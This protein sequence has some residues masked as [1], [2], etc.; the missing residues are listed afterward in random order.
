MS[1]EEE[2]SPYND[3]PEESIAR[4][5]YIT[6]NVET[7]GGNFIGRDKYIDQATDEDI[8]LENLKKRP[9]IFFREKNANFHSINT[10]GGDFIAG[11]VIA[12]HLHIEKIENFESL[13]PQPCH[14]PCIPPYQGLLTFEKEDTKRFFGR[15]QLISR[16]IQK[17]HHT[18][19]LTI[20][21][22]SGS[23]KSSVVRAGVIPAV[24]REKELKRDIPY[25]GGKWQAVVLT[26]TAKPLDHLSYVLSKHVNIAKD[27]LLSQ[28]NEGDD[29]LLTIFKQHS[30]AQS[31]NQLLVVDQFEELFTLCLDEETRQIFIDNLV[32]INSH[33]VTNVKVILI[34]RADYLSHCLAYKKL[35]DY[36]EAYQIFVAQMDGEELTEAIVKPAALGGWKLQDRLLDQILDDIGQEPGALPLLSHVLQETWN[37]RRKNFMTLSGYVEAGRITK[38]IG[39]TAESAFASFSKKEQLVAKRLFLRL[40]EVGNETLVTRRRVRFS[41][42]DDKPELHHVR[43]RLI[44]ARLITANEDGLE[45]AHEALIREWARLTEWIETDRQGLITHRQLTNAA[46]MWDEKG[47]EDSFLYSGLRLL[48]TNQWSQA[49]EAALNALER[50]FL[51]TSLVTETKRQRNKRRL[52][53]WI[54]IGLLILCVVSALALRINDLRGKAVQGQATAVSAQG[55]AETA[56]DV[57]ERQNKSQALASEAT[58][59]LQQNNIIDALGLAV[60]SIETTYLVDKT[61]TSV[62]ETALYRVLATTDSPVLAGGD[63]PLSTEQNLAVFGGSQSPIF[64]IKYEAGSYRVHGAWFSP[65]GQHVLTSRGPIVGLWDMEGTLRVELDGIHGTNLL[66]AEFAPDSSFFVTRELLKDSI[67]IWE[68]NG[69]LRQELCANITT[70]CGLDSHEDNVDLIS[71]SPNGHYIVTVQNGGANGDDVHNVRVRLWNP[72]GQFVTELKGVTAAV[73]T[74]TFDPDSQALL[75][76]HKD[77]TARVWGLEGNQL[78]LFEH[79]EITLALYSP[80]GHHVITAGN[81]GLVY[82]WDISGTLS[83][84]L[85]HD[86][87]IKSVEFSPDE[88]HIILVTDGSTNLN[89][90]RVPVWIWDLNGNLVSKLAI[91]SY[92]SDAKFNLSGTG[93]LTFGRKMQFWTLKGELVE[94]FSLDPSSGDASFSPDGQLLMLTSSEGVWVFDSSSISSYQADFQPPTSFDSAGDSEEQASQLNTATT[95]QSVN[96]PLATLAGHKGSISQIIYSPIRN[97]FLTF[98]RSGDDGN[99]FLW[100][101]N[102]SLLTIFQGEANTIVEASY[103]PDGAHI[104]TINDGK[105]RLWNENGTLVVTLGQ[106]NDNKNVYGA[107]WAKFNDAGD[108]IVTVVSGVAYLWSS[109]GELITTL[110]TT[111]NN[112][113][114]YV[115]RAAFSPTGA[116]FATM[117]GQSVYL[118]NEDG[119]II[120]TLEGHQK[121]VIDTIFSPDN[122]RI[123]TRADDGELKLWNIDGNLLADLKGHTSPISDWSFDSSSQL[124]ATGDSDGNAFLWNYKGE[125]IADIESGNFYFTADGSRLISAA[126]EATYLWNDSGQLLQ[127]HEGTLSPRLSLD[128]TSERYLI[129]ESGIASLWDTEGNLI[130]EFSEYSDEVRYAAFNHTETKVVIGNMRRLYIFDVNE[131]YSTEIIGGGNFVSF[132]KDDSHILTTTGEQIFLWNIAGELV[133]EFMTDNGMEV[134]NVQFNPAGNRIL[135]TTDTNAVVMWK[136]DTFV[137]TEPPPPIEISLHA[138]KTDAA[139]FSSDNEYLLTTSNNWQ[140]EG[141]VV[142][143]WNQNGDFLTSLNGHREDI[144]SLAISSDNDFIVTADRDGVANIWQPNGTL[145]ATLRGHTREIDNIYINLDGTRILTVSSDATVRLW[146]KQ[147]N[148]LALLDGYVDI[149][150]PELQAGFSPDGKF[151]V[152]AGCIKA[153]AQQDSK[154]VRGSAQLWNSLNGELITT[155]PGADENET[156][157]SNGLRIHSLS[158]APDNSRFTFFAA[159]WYV[160]DYSGRSINFLDSTLWTHVA[161]F[162]TDS[163]YFIAAGLRPRGGSNLGWAIVWDRNGEIKTELDLTADNTEILSA[164]ISPDSKYILTSHDDGDLRIWSFDGTL[165]AVLEDGGHGIFSPSGNHIA[166]ANEEGIV[167]VWGKSGDLLFSFPSHSGDVST[168]AFNA[169]GT[170][171]VTVDEQGVLLLWEIYPAID[172][173]ISEA[174]KR[175][176]SFLPNYTDCITDDTRERIPTCF[177]QEYEACLVYLD[178]ETCSEGYTP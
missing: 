69:Q 79:A 158:F 73:S 152:T 23:G 119:E 63:N 89:Q 116:I 148:E 7:K 2:K 59:A 147:G 161:S 178:E 83:Q 48:E 163:E 96:Y 57:T 145:I 46:Q 29:A 136:F 126:R 5:T 156:T 131:T 95:N 141:Y 109:E 154:C 140:E 74:V 1:D 123:L 164:Q 175:L 24:L 138:V 25:L 121:F 128:P 134:I 176:K 170:R 77:G 137:P 120:T 115:W 85:R 129:V 37:R 76:A 17:L 111:S 151:I 26:P 34:L 43:H 124:F 135:A 41:E 38:A 3:F 11:N 114:A 53:R 149:G 177:L 36:I 66:A 103:S 98:N 9:Y 84:T 90:E 8:P 10:Q 6:G 174:R 166:T 112:T 133:A 171:L 91:D 12:N 18:N 97:Q 61:Y 146:D 172:E 45:V 94:Q 39:K 71:I 67:K 60:Q 32:R 102:G 113:M 31:H 157:A 108:R 159:R 110:N 125:K 93:I 130:I 144:T 100:D 142:Y 42:L 173:M 162:S 78:Q 16:I 49:N 54:G 13:G 44:E 132:S 153:H 55:I 160:W 14:P 51:E 68:N 143:L 50:E 40:T 27:Q 99:I 150:W 56:K 21:G 92:I 165:I 47:R 86:R 19:F 106:T 4:G 155:L 80:D 28:L 20:T 64:Q 127:S 70:D 122:Q 22:A 107:L 82:I 35:K 118:W 87:P 33:S 167:S 81:D 169:D 88:F 52:N 62:A 65:D 15:D 117:E 168:M 101:D 30:N 105:I 104:L 139:W 72:D 58:Q 75:T